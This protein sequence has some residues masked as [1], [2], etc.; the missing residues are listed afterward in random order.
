MTV[1]PNELYAKDPIMRAVCRKHKVLPGA[2]LEAVEHLKVAFAK[3]WRKAHPE[4]TDEEIARLFKKAFTSTKP[5]ESQ[6]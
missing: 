6:R 1:D 2:V 3:R 5:K 4:A